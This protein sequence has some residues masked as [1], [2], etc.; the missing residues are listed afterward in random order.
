MLRTFTDVTL[1]KANNQ[2]GDS[3]SNKAMGR[4]V[5][6]EDMSQWQ[7]I[8]F[9]LLQVE[10]ENGAT[11]FMEQI[12]KRCYFLIVVILWFCLFISELKQSK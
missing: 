3:I 11:V 7:D 2:L 4:C 8:I 9:D 12:S 10:L 5:Q 6:G 1:C